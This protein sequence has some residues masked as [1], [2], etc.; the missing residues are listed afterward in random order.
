MTFFLGNSK[1]IIKKE[2]DALNQADHIVKVLRMVTIFGLCLPPKMRISVNPEGKCIGYKKP[3]N[4]T[5][6]AVNPVEGKDVAMTL[7]VTYVRS[8]SYPSC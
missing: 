2:Y 7:L 3:K 6:M 1:N 5:H 8:K 4:M